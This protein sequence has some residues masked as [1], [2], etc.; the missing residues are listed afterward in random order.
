V[1]RTSRTRLAAAVLAVGASGCAAYRPAPLDVE[2]PLRATTKLAG[3]IAY[4]AAVRTAV[5]RNP[6]LTA[7]RARASAVNLRPT[8]EPIEVSGGVDADHRAEATVALDAL[9]LL[10]LGVNRADRVL[11]YARRDE[12]LLAHHVRAR[13]IAGEIA[14]AFAVE[15]A[16]NDLPAADLSVDASIYVRAGFASSSAETAA[17][18]TKEDWAAEAAVRVFERQSNR[19]ALARLLGMTPADV[20]PAA[21]PDAWPPVPA[22][23]PRAVLAA[24]AEIQRRVA[25]FEV[26]DAE[27]RRA[28]A[29]Q[30]PAL[31]LE[32]GIAADP[33]SLFGAVRLRIPVGASGE[34]RAAECA[35]EAA[36][37][38]VESAVLDA[39]RDASRSRQELVA[40]SAVRAAAERRLEA[41]AELFRV[42][43]TRLEVS[44]GSVVE[45]VLSADAVVDAARAVREARVAEAKARVRA[46]LDAGWPAP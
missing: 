8:K 29:A 35:R 3:P 27:L 24:R 21:V 30:Y 42:G 5:E 45:V 2:R 1:N 22:A 12:A 15:R 11:A 31:V 46:A 14:E 6:D 13:E 40:A 4:E 44:D 7:L 28:V 10:G 33:T 41:N 25:A 37:G 18:A 20:V 16:L 32:P 36:R 39:L 34:V 17:A 23:E 26:A 38:D 43:R 19:L 9:S